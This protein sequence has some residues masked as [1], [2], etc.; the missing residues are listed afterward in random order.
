MGTASGRP[1]RLL[2]FRHVQSPDW[3]WRRAHDLLVRPDG[4]RSDE[5]PP[6]LRALHHL[7]QVQDG[8][9][10]SAADPISRALGIYAADTPL[11]WKLEA[12]LV[13]RQTSRTIAPRLKLDR[14]SVKWYRAL[15]YDARSWM[16]KVRTTASLIGYYPLAG[17]PE[18]DLA[19]LWK[20]VAARRGL[21]GLDRVLAVTAGEGRDRFRPEELDDAALYIETLRIPL[22]RDRD[23]NRLQA[24]AAVED[25]GLPASTYYRPRRRK[26]GPSKPVQDPITGEWLGPGCSRMPGG[27]RDPVVQSKSP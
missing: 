16:R 19:G 15:F 13:A 20:H 22:T 24:R 4:N 12:L 25:A 9:A 8:I 10:P 17:I 26:R 14:D 7:Q 27:P 5:D 18:T 1:G 21:E 23:L 2:R 11:R 6:T 3:R